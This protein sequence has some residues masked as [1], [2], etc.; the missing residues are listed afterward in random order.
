RAAFSGAG[1]TLTGSSRPGASSQSAG[2]SGSTPK[3]KTRWGKG[4]TLSGQ[5]V[6]DIDED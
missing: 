6:I 1:Q 4:N 3:P 5:E 2:P